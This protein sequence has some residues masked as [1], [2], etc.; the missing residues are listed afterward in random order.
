MTTAVLD[1][2]KRAGGINAVPYRIHPKL[3]EML[4]AASVAN[5]MPMC[6][7]VEEGTGDSVGGEG[8][9]RQM[10]FLFFMAW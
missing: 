5:A 4:S 9:E 7:Q 10:F 3:A 6:F 8:A 2:S 1:G